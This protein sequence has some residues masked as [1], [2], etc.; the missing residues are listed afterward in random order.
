LFVHLGLSTGAAYEE[1]RETQNEK[2]RFH[3]HQN[4]SLRFA[5]P[6]SGNEPGQR[7]YGLENAEKHRSIIASHFSFFGCRVS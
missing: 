4:P 3:T 6:N 1:H 5:E 7:Y 2:W